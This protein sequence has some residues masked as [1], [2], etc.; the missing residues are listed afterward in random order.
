MFTID[1]TQAEGNAPYFAA[2]L[3]MVYLSRMVALLDMDDGD[4]RLSIGERMQDG[5]D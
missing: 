1:I 2:V 4:W 5:E 3:K